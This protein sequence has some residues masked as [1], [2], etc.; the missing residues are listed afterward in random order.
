MRLDS[1]DLTSIKFK[2]AL[3][4]DFSDEVAPHY[5]VV[6][7]SEAEAQVRP[8][9]TDINSI[10]H[11]YINIVYYFSFLFNLFYFSF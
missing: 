11:I 3:N 1:I 7:Q 8:S 6:K 4:C 10:F 2:N 5:D 9:L